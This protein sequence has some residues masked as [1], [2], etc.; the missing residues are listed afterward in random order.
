MQRK[1]ACPLLGV[2]GQEG[3]GPVCQLWSHHQGP[4]GK[5]ACLLIQPQE[6]EQAGGPTT[7]LLRT[8]AVNL[9]C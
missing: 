4:A 6:A 5:T 1:R 3:G 7:W 9:A 8:V 2:E